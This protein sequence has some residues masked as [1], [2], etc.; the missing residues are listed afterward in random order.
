MRVLI[1]EDDMFLG[2]VLRDYLQE[3]GHEKVVVSSTGGEGADALASDTFDCVFVDLNLPDMLG[4]ELL[5]T[6][7]SRDSSLPVIMM[8]GFPTMEYTI[9]AMRKGAS[10]FLTKPFT[11]QQLALTLNRVTKERSLF[12][13]NVRLKLEIEAR[14]QLEIVNHQLAERVREQTRLF[15]ISREIDKAGSNENLYHG[16]VGLSSQLT[17][18]HK[19]GFFLLPPE[20]ENLVLISGQGLNGSS[21]CFPCISIDAGQLRQF[22]AGDQGPV[23]L[24]AQALMEPDA[25]ARWGLEACVASCWPLKIRGELFGLI[26]AFLENGNHEIP[27]SEMKLMDFLTKK[28]SLAIENMALYESLVANFYGIL[29]SLVNALE[30]KDPYTGKHSERVTGYAV[31]TARVLGCETAHIEAL[32]TT[33]HLHD[34]GKIGIADVILNKPDKLTFEEYK[35]IQQH[36]VIGESIV[37]DLGLSREEAAIIRHHHERWDGRGYPD[38]L[39]GKDIPLLARIVTVADA[40]DAMTSKRAYRAS[41]SHA[42]ALLEVTENRGKQFDPEI[43]DAFVE[44][45]KKPT[46]KEDT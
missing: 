32:Q 2:E 20:R 29:R 1:V 13:E 8:S 46:N 33:G 9:E 3:L 21:A 15:E 6:M 41:M 7:K 26:M 42:D 45:I 35:L 44:M 18:T 36:P 16:V 19:V 31:R 24:P 25:V 27:P 14:R 22:T 38:G 23:I 40:F 5:D 12:L 34:L 11:L 4:F 30:A 43:A 28:A 17:N 10:D 39:A 37:A